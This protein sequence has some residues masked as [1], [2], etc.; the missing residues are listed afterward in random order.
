M[1]SY[2]SILSRV[3]IGIATALI[4]AGAAMVVVAAKPG[5]RSSGVDPTEIAPTADNA[6]VN[7]SIPGGGRSPAHVTAAFRPRPTP[8]AVVDP[9]TELG[10]NLSGLNFFNQRFDADGGNQF[11]VEPPDQGLCV[12]NGVVLEAVNTVLAFYDASTGAQIGGFESLNQ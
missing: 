8:L 11:S 5:V 3:R 10:L 7:R 1:K 2:N 4:S 12:G 6:I 9:G